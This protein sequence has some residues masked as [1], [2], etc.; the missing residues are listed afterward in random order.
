MKRREKKISV[1]KPTAGQLAQSVDPNI[2]QTP[3]LELIDQKLEWAFSTPGARLAISVPP[4][5]GKTTRVGVWGVLRA[6]VQNPER[7]IVAASYS[8]MLARS[9]ARTA[10]NII[11]EHGSGAKDPLTGASLPD[12]LGLALSSD[13]SASGNWQL[14]GH[15]GGYYAVGTGG[16]LTGRAADCLIIDDP[17]K[18]QIQADSAREREKVW[19]WWTSVAQTRLSPTASVIIINTRWHNDDLVGRIIEQERQLEAENRTWDIINIPAIAEEGVPDALGREPGEALI[20]ARGRS[21]EEFK[22]IRH[23]VGER[24]WAAL[25]QGLPTPLEG[26]LFSR[27][28]FNRSRV[29]CVDL[30]GKIVT[31]DPAESGRGDEAGI[32]VMGWDANGS[33]Y[34]VEDH[35]RRLTS[36]EWSRVA[37]V[38]ALMSS[39]SVILYEAFTAETTYRNVL[40]ST[41]RDMHRQAQLLRENNL[42]VATAATAYVEE[43]ASGDVV[44]QLQE[45]LEIIDKIPDE[46]FPP[47][48][49][50][51]WRKRGDKVARAAGARQSVTTGALRMIGEHKVLETQAATWLPGQGSPDRV[52]AMVNGHDFILKSMG[53]QVEV[54]FPGQF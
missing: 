8:E 1:K 49:L 33:M 41:W 17:F 5:E 52:D 16:S 46:E 2:V 53:Q 24:T 22:Q 7:R 27:E 44:G 45:T 36:A 42:D 6:L 13:K 31:V 15:D 30:I 51:P 14:A 26:G 50:E 29:D 11:A 25:Y 47:F 18:D 10:R 39:A 43:G 19:E 4:Q 35:S 21:L 23:N 38:Q 54:A 32:L 34:V 20:S 40:E 48:T 3:A 28:E 12:K 9:T 37:V